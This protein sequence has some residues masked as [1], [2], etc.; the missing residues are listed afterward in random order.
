M[1][2]IYNG[3]TNATSG[4]EGHVKS[5]DELIDMGLSIPKSI[6]DDGGSSENPEQLFGVPTQ[7]VL[8]EHYRPYKKYIK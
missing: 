5:E 3:T 2:T 6:G 8:V 1:A 4:R 7:F